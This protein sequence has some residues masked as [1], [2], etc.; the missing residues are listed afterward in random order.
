MSAP[1]DWT[2]RKFTPDSTRVGRVW[3]SHGVLVLLLTVA[4]L[5]L[6]G[7]LGYLVLADP[8]AKDMFGLELSLSLQGEPNS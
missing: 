3:G 2:L 6:A 1:V 5:A 4:A 8:S 7:T